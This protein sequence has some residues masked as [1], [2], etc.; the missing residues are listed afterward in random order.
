[1]YNENNVTII[2]VTTKES[3]TILEENTGGNFVV[4]QNN[5]VIA[6]TYNL[7]QALDIA[8]IVLNRTAENA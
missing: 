2:S 7:K 8:A 6:R 1:M 5:D 3:V 4:K